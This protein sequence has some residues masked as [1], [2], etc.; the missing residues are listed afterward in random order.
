MGQGESAAKTT[1]GERLGF[2]P[3]ARVAIV[4]CDDIGMCHAANVGAFEALDRGPATCGS[5]MVPC[6]WFPEAAAMAREREG[7]DLGVHLT[8]TSEWETYR[9]GPVADASQ[10][11]S[12]VDPDG[13][14]PRTTAEVLSR[15]DPAEAEVEL[16]AQIDRALEAGIDVTHLDAHMG[17]AMMPPI[18]DVYTRLA[19]EYRLPVFA[20]RPDA[21]LLAALGHGESGNAVTCAMDAFESGGGPI[22]DGMDS[23]SLHFAPGEGAE[24]NARRL[25]GL[26]AGVSYL[27]CHPALNGEELQAIT[28]DAHCRD[29]ERR[30]YGGEEGRLALEAAEIRTLGMRTL[31]DLMR[32]E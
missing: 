6:P 32:G 25:Y 11:P 19:L 21:T 29:F 10:V 24:H 23:N 3:D 7:I 17:A 14:F 26:P 2:A 27:I 18:L 22:L 1:L 13:G 31:R 5:V 15:A 20:F 8:L 12:L 30:Y 28:A 16:R 4:H 9:W